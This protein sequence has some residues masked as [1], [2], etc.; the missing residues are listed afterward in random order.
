MRRSRGESRAWIE[1]SERTPVWLA[2]DAVRCEPVSCQN[3]L[4]TGKIQGN[5]RA[6]GLHLDYSRPIAQPLQAL[7]A[8]FPTH[9]NREF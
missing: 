6:L 2:E 3:S 8:K 9:A 5:L 1:F 7:A 4:I